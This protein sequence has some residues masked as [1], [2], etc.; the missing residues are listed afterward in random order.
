MQYTHKERKKDDKQAW[1]T[2]EKEQS[3]VNRK[4]DILRKHHMLLQA[5][6]LVSYYKT[7]TR[8]TNLQS[9]CR[10]HSLTGP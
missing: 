6:G 8:Q 9:L 1:V 10:Y 2:A 7:I 4:D 5:V 3:Q